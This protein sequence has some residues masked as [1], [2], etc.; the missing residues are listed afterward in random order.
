[1]DSFLDKFL[2]KLLRQ[3][4]F[5]KIKKYI[6]E[7]SVVCDLGCGKDAQF[8]KNISSFIAGGP[9]GY[10][11]K[12]AIKQGIGLDSAIEDYGGSNLELK[13]IKIEKNLPL[14]N[15]S[16][17]IITM[18]ALIEHLSH[19][20][21][22]LN[23]CFRCLKP[24]G[25]LIITTPTPLARPILEFLAYWLHLINEKEISDHKNYFWPKNLKQML[26]RA[27]FNRENIKSHF[28]ELFFNNLTISQKIA[29]KIQ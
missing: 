13:N 1:M 2:D 7:D 20:Q 23:E 27:G 18:V 9:T 10:V 17:D 28:F 21:E 26:V 16:C 15:E 11:A 8:L 4:R 12:G 19:P 22:V 25:K 14:G 3:E 29:Q 6:P 24:A 5:R